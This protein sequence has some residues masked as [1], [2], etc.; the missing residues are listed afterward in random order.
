MFSQI[1]EFIYTVICRPKLVKN[2]INKLLLLVIPEYIEKGKS[3]IYLNSED[4]VISSAL[5]FG[6]YENAETVFL[7]RNLGEKDLFIDVGANIGY[8]SVMALEKIGDGGIILSIEPE[9]KSYE[10]LQKNI[11]INNGDG[12]SRLFS[13]ALSDKLGKQNLY[14]SKDNKGDNRLFDFNEGGDIIEIE[15]TTLDLLLDKECIDIS[16]RKTFI[17]ID[18][19]G[20]EGNVLEGMRESITKCNN[21]IILMEFW[22]QGLQNMQFDPLSVL[23]DLESCGFVLS[24]LTQEGE[25]LKINDK[26]K[27]ITKYKGRAYTNIICAKHA[28]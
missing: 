28:K 13:F 6:I 10:I 14:L 3:R 2:T 24:E 23:N 15:T 16:N 12:I 5:F 9:P 4:P 22:P 17:K 11:A 20:G 7:K 8:Y 21:I 1:A 18:V 26:G 27:F 19:Q 25:A